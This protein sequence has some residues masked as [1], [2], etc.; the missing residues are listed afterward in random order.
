MKTT[1]NIPNDL[2]EEARRASGKKTKTATVV[3]ALKELIRQKKVQTILENA[4]KLDFADWEE[5]RHGR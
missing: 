4:G 1:L 3:A 5:S 2:L